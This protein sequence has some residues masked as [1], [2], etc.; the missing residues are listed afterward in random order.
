MAAYTWYHITGVYIAS[1]QTA[2]IYVDGQLVG[3]MTDLPS[4]TATGDLDIGRDLYTGYQ[5]DYFPGEISNVETWNTA[6]SPGQVATL[7]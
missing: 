2:Q 6:L 5:V 1:T 4:W 3:S 7:D